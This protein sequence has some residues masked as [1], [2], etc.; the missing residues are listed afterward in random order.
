MLQQQNARE[1][2]DAAIQLGTLSD[3]PSAP[4]YAGEFMYMGTDT[5]R[6]HAFKHRDTREYIYTGD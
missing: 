1:A 6:G 2:F 3:E 4:N 5:E